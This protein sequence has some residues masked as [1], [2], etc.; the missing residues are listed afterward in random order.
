MLLLWLYCQGHLCMHGSQ[1]V[2]TRIS[3]L[4][5]ASSAIGSKSC[6]CL[7]VIFVM[8]LPLL[9]V[10]RRRVPSLIA[11][12]KLSRKSHVYFVVLGDQCKCGVLS[13]G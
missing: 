9:L 3:M 10:E 13:S 6:D 7:H 2:A 4:V 11:F 5:S 8:F 12:S 1:V